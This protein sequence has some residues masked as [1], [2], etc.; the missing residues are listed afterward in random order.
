MPY[1]DVNSGLERVGG[2]VKLYKNILIK[3]QR[4]YSDSASTIKSALE[5]GDRKGAEILAHTLKGVSG[6]IGASDLHPVASALEAGIK[7]RRNDQYRGLLDN[8][9]KNLGRVLGSIKSLVP[10]EGES[11]KEKKDGPPMKPETLLELLKNLQTHVQSRKPK[12]CAPIMEE[13]L[14]ASFPDIFGKEIKELDQ[15]IEK[16]NF[17]EAQTVLESIVQGLE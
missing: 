9:E 8:F 2:N 14:K 5:R 17:K 10:E 13:I 3:F 12:K 11:N 15:L 4:D 16:Y 6:S 1:I 7:H